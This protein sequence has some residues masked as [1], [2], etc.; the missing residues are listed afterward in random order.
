MLGGECVGNRLGRVARLPKEPEASQVSHRHTSRGSCDRIFA[1]KPIAHAAPPE[2]PASNCALS[3]GDLSVLGDVCDAAAAAAAWF[4]ANLSCRWFNRRFSK[5]FPHGLPSPRSDQSCFK[6]GKPW[7]ELLQQTLAEEAAQV[8]IVCQEAPTGGKR[9]LRMATSLWQEGV[10]FV[11]TDVTSERR[12][13]EVILQNQ[14]LDHLGGVAAGVAHDFNNVLAGILGVAALLKDG[15]APD[16]PQRALVDEIERVGS[17]A[18]S[19]TRQILD[20]VRQGEDEAEVVDLRDCAREVVDLLRRS[21]DPKVCIKARLDSR[22]AP[23]RM[24]KG[25]VQQVIMNLCCNARDAM[26]AGGDLTVAVNVHGDTATLRVRDTG[27]GMSHETLEHIFDPFFT[28]KGPGKG[29]GLGLPVC[30]EIVL[31]V[32]GDLRVE[33]TPAQGTLFEVYL[34]LVR[35]WAGPS[36]RDGRTAFVDAPRGKRILVVDDEP[37]VRMVAERFLR[38]EGYEVISVQDGDEALAMLRGAEPWID[39]AIVDLTMPG[40]SGAEVVIAARDF[41]PTLPILISSG[42]SEAAIEDRSWAIE[43]QGFLQK[44]YQRAA[45]LATVAR[46]LTPDAAVA[47]ARLSPSGGSRS[48]QGDD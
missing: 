4:D 48:Q 3:N 10:L 20:F 18:T 11:V 25:R 1:V 15:L 14:K 5:W 27:M 43:V 22:P 47:P 12:I 35:D 34:P 21:V 13:K 41:R 26:P 31:G 7:E 6:S 17:S 39:L 33:S 19:L 42:Y 30:R 16:D 36:S 46:L 23:I 29:T 40:T 8:G 24:D 37:L 28:T 38:R 2:V 32:G 45:L 9:W 44:P